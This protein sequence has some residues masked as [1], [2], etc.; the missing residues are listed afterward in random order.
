MDGDIEGN[1]NGVKYTIG[2]AVLEQ[3][4]LHNI[5]AVKEVEEALNTLIKEER[6]T[7]ANQSNAR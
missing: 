2:K 3:L 4:K 6:P 7:D 1:V 5:D